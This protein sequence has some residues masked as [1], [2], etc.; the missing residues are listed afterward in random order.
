MSMS[1]NSDDFS[2]AINVYPFRELV[3]DVL[4]PVA[5]GTLEQL[6]SPILEIYGLDQ[7]LDAP[8]PLAQRA[9]HAER[10][11]GRVR[12]IIRML[13]PEVSPLP[14]EVF[15]AVEFLVHEVRGE[16]VHLG[17]A[18]LRLEFLADEI[19][20]RPLLHDLVMGRAN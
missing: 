13:P 12:R 18:I 6:T 4:S 9:E 17:Q 1:M 5:L 2:A 10:L 3:S 11:V 20:A 7:L 19:R 16:P 8:L 15:T 14:N